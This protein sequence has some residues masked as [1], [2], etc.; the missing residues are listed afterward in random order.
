MSARQL[1]LVELIA[2]MLRFLA[3][4]DVGEAEWCAERIRQME[5]P[6]LDR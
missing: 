4:G 5:D 6:T 1:L 3:I 2:D